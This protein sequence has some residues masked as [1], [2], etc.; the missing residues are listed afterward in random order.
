MKMGCHT[1]SFLALAAAVGCSAVNAPSPQPSAVP[2]AAEAHPTSAPADRICVRIVT[3]AD[4]EPVLIMRP[5][6]NDHFP[7]CTLKLYNRASEPVVI[8]YTPNCVTVHCGPFEQQ[9]PGVTFVHR[10]EIVD[11][12]SA[13]ELEIPPGSWTMTD[14]EIMVPTTL[15]AGPYESWAAFKLEGASSAQ[16]ATRHTTFTAP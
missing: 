10:R 4:L 2:A 1:I 14:G 7:I 6:P 5:N 15:P 9:G 13:L 3:T 11:P 8:G 16:I 12:Q